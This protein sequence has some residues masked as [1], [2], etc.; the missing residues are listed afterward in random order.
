[1]SV[2]KSG[3]GVG[4]RGRRSLARALGGARRGAAA[5]RRRRAE[6][7]CIHVGTLA[8]LIARSQRRTSAT[9]GSRNSQSSTSIHHGRHTH[10]DARGARRGA[11]KKAADRGRQG[12]E[13]RREG[14]A[15]GGARERAGEEGG[16]GARPVAHA[17]DV[18]RALVRQPLH[19]I[20]DQVGPQLGARR[21]ARAAAQEERGVGAR[22]RGDVAEA[23]EGAHLPPAPPADPHGAGGGGRRGL[24]R[25]LRRR[26]AGGVRSSTCAPR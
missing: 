2:L 3:P 17:A 24:G 18:R 21:G 23:G 12:E 6:P 4:R 1:M 26:A 15:P 7:L 9:G 13:G 8:S 20:G 5:E 10:S 16:V 11:P 22:A 19:Q 25:R 14:G